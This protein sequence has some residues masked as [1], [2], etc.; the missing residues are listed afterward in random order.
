MSVLVVICV[1]NQVRHEITSKETRTVH[2]LSS[3]FV[4]VAA[5]Y[6]SRQLGNVDDKCDMQPRKL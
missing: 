1:Q 3:F 5:N 2:S 6:L 4:L